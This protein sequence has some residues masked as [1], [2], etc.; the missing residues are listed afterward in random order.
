[1]NMSLLNCPLQIV[2]AKLV[3]DRRFI[4]ADLG[5]EIAVGDSGNRRDLFAEALLVCAPREL[6]HPSA[7]ALARRLEVGVTFARLVECRQ[8]T[9]GDL[10][11]MDVEVE[12]P[13]RPAYDIR[14]EERIAIWFAAPP[15]SALPALQS[16]ATDRFRVGQ[17]AR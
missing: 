4:G 3:R 11:V 15:A 10:V 6:R 17:R 16:T 9:A 2:I 7:R 13:Q 12:T 5:I 1:M 8:G 14:F